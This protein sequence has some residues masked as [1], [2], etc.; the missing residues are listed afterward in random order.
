MILQLATPERASYFWSSAEGSACLFLDTRQKS[1][2]LHRRERH[3]RAELSCPS[4]EGGP[5][6]VLT[7]SPRGCPTPTP[8]VPALHSESQLHATYSC[9]T[10]AWAVGQTAELGNYQKRDRFIDLRSIF[11]KG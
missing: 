4:E 2:H 8:S 1:P 10:P 9:N 5:L 11:A 7:K 3:P 6:T